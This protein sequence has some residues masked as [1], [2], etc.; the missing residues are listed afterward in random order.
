V[1][2]V[3]T[4]L[5][6]YEFIWFFVEESVSENL[7]CLN[8]FK[9][10]QVGLQYPEKSIYKVLSHVQEVD[11]VKVPILSR[12]IHRPSSAPFSAIGV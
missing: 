9:F 6:V 2:D 10:V 11:N 5:Y 8:L 4:T 3:H 1:W 12:R 7:N